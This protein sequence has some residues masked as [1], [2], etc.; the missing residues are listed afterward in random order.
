MAQQPVSCLPTMLM[1]VGFEQRTTIQYDSYSVSPATARLSTQETLEELFKC[2]TFYDLLSERDKQLAAAKDEL[3]VQREEA[4]KLLLAV[5]HH[6][7]VAAQKQARLVSRVRAV[8]SEYR[9]SS[10]LTRLLPRMQVF[11]AWK[12]VWALARQRKKFLR[13]HALAPMIHA[14]TKREVFSAWWALVLASRVQKLKDAQSRKDSMSKQVQR[15]LDDERDAHQRTRDV[16]VVLVLGAVLVLC[17]LTLH[18]IPSTH[19]QR[20]AAVERELASAKLRADRVKHA[21]T[22]LL[23]QQK[24][25]RAA[26]CVWRVS[27][28]C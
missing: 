22:S 6:T 10:P 2:R 4:A 19:V 18:C 27:C 13:S 3:R 15:Q 23:A 8:S 7:R 25:V 11:F 12:S 14:I 21:A 26:A 1:C 17:C 16:R 28:H 9:G 5:T 24:D 20:L